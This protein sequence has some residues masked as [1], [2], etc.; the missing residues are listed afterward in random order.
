MHF[1]KTHLRALP[2]FLFPIAYVLQNPFLEPYGESSTLKLYHIVALLII[3][4]LR[5]YLQ[6]TAILLALLYLISIL[7]PTFINPF[8]NTRTVNGVLFTLT[9]IGS[10]GASAIDRKYASNGSLVAVALIS[11]KMLYQL[12]VILT[13]AY[14][15]IEGR[16]LYPTFMAGGVNIEI[17]TLF[18]LTLFSLSKLPHIQLTLLTISFFLTKTRSLGLIPIA[19]ILANLQ[20]QKPA[21]NNK[22]KRPPL[23]LTISAFALLLFLLNQTGF[24]EIEK[25]TSR[26]TQIFGGEPGSDGRILLYQVALNSSHCFVLGCGLGSATAA[27]ASSPLAEFFEDNFHNVYLQ[28]LFEL[29]MLGALTYLTLFITSI[30]H[31]RRKIQDIGLTS[32][33]LAVFLLNAVQFNGFELLTAFLLGLGLSHASQNPCNNN[34]CEQRQPLL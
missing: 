20:T 8:I 15:N 26:I 30:R 21:R 11:A 34:L 24:I 2:F 32:A 19:Q 5:I 25:I 14:E 31:S 23:L 13:S 6:K 16:P 12:P 29:G 4:N 7:I 3:L 18:I 33:L 27:I 10:S 9:L 28:Q 22:K 1:K 17:T